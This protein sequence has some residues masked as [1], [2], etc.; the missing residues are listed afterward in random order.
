MSNSPTSFRFPFQLPEG[1][2]TAQVHPLVAQAIRYS[3]SGIIDLQ[4]AI[5]KLNTKVAPAVKAAAAASTATTAGGSSTSFTVNVGGVNDQSGNVSYALAQSDFGAIIIVDTSSPFA[6]SLNNGVGAPFYAVIENLG[7]GLLTATPVTGQVNG[8]GTFTLESGQSGLAYFDG[9]NWWITTLPQYL[10]GGS[11]GFGRVV[12]DSGAL[13]T[14]PILNGTIFID[15]GSVVSFGPGA[16][17]I[18]LFSDAE[19]PSGTVDGVNKVF[20][21]LHAPNQ[22][23]SLEMYKNG[24][25]QSAGVDYALT[26]S[27]IT[28]VTAPPISS[29]LICWYRY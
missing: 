2:E 26:G 25:L 17:I 28:F 9:T 3:F 15:S 22:A 7:N 10:L 16:T 14:S 27:T 11:T 24:L 4:N 21:L 23:A 18:G 19:T 5:E 12:L 29:T 1:D 8:A 20:T 13:L 6:L